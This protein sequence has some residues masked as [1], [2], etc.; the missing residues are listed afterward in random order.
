MFGLIN[1]IKDQKNKLGIGHLVG[2]PHRYA[3]D[4]WK[5]LLPFSP[6]NLG[7]WSI[8]GIMLNQETAVI[9][10]QLIKQMTD[11]YHCDNDHLE[12][13]VTS[14]ATEANIFSAWIGRKY[15]L[16]KSINIKQI[17]LVRTSLTHYS[18]EKTADII[19]ISTAKTALHDTSWNMDIG[20]FEKTVRKL[21]E[22][23]YRGFLLPLTIG[24]TIT[25][26]SDPYKEICE[27]IDVLEK[28][29]KVK[30]FV[31]IDAALNGLIEP[32]LDNKFRPFDHLQI[33]TLSTDFHKFGS[34]PIPSGIILYRKHL[35][36]LIEKPIDYL[37]EKDNTLLGSRSGIAPVA[38]WIIVNY[39]GRQFF[40]EKIQSCLKE[41]NKFINQMKAYKSVRLINV[42]TSLNFALVQT[43]AKADLLK[44]ENKYG[45]KFRKNTYLFVKGNKSVN[46][47]K[48]YFLNY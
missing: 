18:I 48:A 38:C 46:I 24:Y 10:R 33:Q 31:W 11:L 34:A 47:A 4:I 42:S 3:V 17:I 8:K 39:L 30:F 13:Y 45:L 29:L 32:F 20:G 44:I 36:Q 15:L 23:N 2:Y 43:G 28:Q 14:G 35:R 40:T 25:G 41:K 37:D 7:N 19:G 16:S 9:E 26:T 21:A 27:K 22:K 6:N 12:G 1:K 5:K